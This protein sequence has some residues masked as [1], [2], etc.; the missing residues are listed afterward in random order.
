MNSTEVLERLRPLTDV[1]V[2]N[3][4]HKPKTRIVVEPDQ[5]ILHPNSGGS[6][7]HLNEQGVRSLAN[8]VGMPLSM[9][10]QISPELFGRVATELLARKEKYSVLVKDQ[11]IID[12]GNP[13]AT[14]NLA[15]E[16]II[17]T[18]GQIIPGAEYNR[19]VT[20]KDYSA[21]LEILG[22]KREP[23]VRGDLIRAGAL[24]KFSPIGTI[25]PSVQSFVV[26]LAC[27]NGATDTRVLRE[28]GGHGEGDDLWQ[29]FRKSIKDAYGALEGIV[30]RYREMVGDRI[31]AEQRALML[32]DLLNR[33]KITGEVADAVRTR[34][35]AEPPRNAYEMF[36]LITW[37]STHL[38]KEPAQVTRA[39][40]TA[41]QFVSVSE[42]STL[43]PVCHSRH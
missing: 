34:A 2:R 6:V 38:I 35:I 37:A 43:C 8:F 28:F 16:R 1:E 40:S 31:T 42:H 18:I 21:E 13:G 41:A 25:M 36:N 15:P 39:R 11:S 19:V 14:R 9:G 22:E 17:Q 4:E 30:N 33:A 3:I 7:V 32:E 20:G 27:T 26:R 23:V 12:F 24:V 29:W 5:V 10:K